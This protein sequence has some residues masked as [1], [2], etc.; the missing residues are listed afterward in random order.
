MTIETNI[1]DILKSATIRI[2]HNKKN[3][4]AQHTGF[5]I[6]PNIALATVHSFQHG[7]LPQRGI[8]GAMQ[9]VDVVHPATKEHRLVEDII[10]PIGIDM[11]AIRLSSSIKA[12]Y[13][14]IAADEAEEGCPITTV[15]TRIKNKDVIR[16]INS[17]NLIRAAK[18]ED[19]EI[20]KGLVSSRNTALSNLFA[21][22]SIDRNTSSSSYLFDLSNALPGMSGSAIACSSSK[23]C[24]SM[25]TRTGPRHNLAAGIPQKILHEF[26]S[27]VL[28]D[29]SF[30]SAVQIYGDQSST[31][32]LKYQISII[33]QH[34]L[35]AC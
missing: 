5:L 35:E 20:R 4:H 33:P 6:A 32:R 22:Q 9:N 8:K 24:V 14:T 30:K 15:D 26:S 34:I 10:A 29:P 16:N 28:S 21:A 19:I 13:L 7:N 17:L 11:V 1:D 31:S 27:A 25:L 23:K 12:H 3:E 2:L 18:D